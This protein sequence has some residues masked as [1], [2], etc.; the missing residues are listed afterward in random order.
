MK[1]KLITD[2][3]RKL[4]FNMAAIDAYTGRWKP[5]TPIEVEIK[6]RAVPKDP[7]RKYYFAAV[8]KPY[9]DHLGYD[10]GEETELLHRQLKIVWYQVEPDKK[11]IYKGVPTLFRNESDKGVGEKQEFINWVVR[12]AARD[13]VYIE[14]TT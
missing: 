12:C 3:K 8:L 6:R 10:Q 2:D 11:G 9:A 1:F 7:I 4:S 5:G 14:T 13:G